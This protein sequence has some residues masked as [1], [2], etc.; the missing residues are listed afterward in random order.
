MNTLT[1]PRRIRNPTSDYDTTCHAPFLASA[2]HDNVFPLSKA[3]G[4][5]S[6][7]D[8]SATTVLLRH[9]LITT[10]LLEFMLNSLELREHRAYTRLIP[11]ELV[12]QFHA[13]DRGVCSLEETLQLTDR[14][15]DVLA[16]VLSS[17]VSDVEIH[18]AVLQCLD[19]VAV[20]FS[21]AEL[22]HVAPPGSGR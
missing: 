22:V 9:L 20:T 4:T 12:V 1:D 8:P 16:D 10:H 17:H 11:M 15:R 3:H 6:K 19:F 2:A 5:A 14:R 7:T 13:F 21:L 18:D